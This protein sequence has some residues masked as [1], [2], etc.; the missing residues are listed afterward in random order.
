MELGAFPTSYIPTQET[1]TGRTSIGTYIGSNGFIQTAASDVA[2]YT[3]NPQ[4]LSV[5]PY[6]LLEESRTNLQLHS[7]DFSNT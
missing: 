3:Y 5:A 2:R 1:F 7:E 6:L 4:N